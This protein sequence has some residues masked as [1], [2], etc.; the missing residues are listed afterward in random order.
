MTPVYMA[1]LSLKVRLPNV[2]IQK[3]NG[4]TFKMFE[5]VLASFQV[6]NILEKAQ[7]FQKP[8]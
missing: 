8:S 2:G 3:I 4:S 5:M 7:F 1:S 6:K